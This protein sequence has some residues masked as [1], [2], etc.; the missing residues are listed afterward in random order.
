VRSR[1][2]KRLMRL[3]GERVERSFAHCYETGGMRRTHLRGHSNIL[4]RLLMHVAG[5]NLGL[6]MRSLFGIGKPRVLQGLATRFSRH[7]C[8]R[9]ENWT[10]TWSHFLLWLYDWARGSDLLVLRCWHRTA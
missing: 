9:P 1:R 5:F 3:R 6:V 4:K 7:S 8:D 10:A 2:G